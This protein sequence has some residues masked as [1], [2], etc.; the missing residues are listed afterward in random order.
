[1][2]GLGAH[3]NQHPQGK[4]HGKDKIADGK[5]DGVV[6][7]QRGCDDPWRI[8]AASDLNCDEQGTEG[9]DEK[10]K[11][12]RTDHLKHRPR[13]CHGQAKKC[14]RFVDPSSPQKPAAEPVGDTGGNRV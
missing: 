6:P 9:E 4:Q 3:F 14:G 2:D 5:P 8:L 11:V 7:Q 1:M 10:R 12:G 13:I